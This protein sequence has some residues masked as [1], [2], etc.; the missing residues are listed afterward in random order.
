SAPYILQ[1]KAAPQSEPTA[2]RTPPPIEKSI[3]N[4]KREAS[5]ILVDRLAS[6]IKLFAMEEEGQAILDEME[7]TNISVQSVSTRFWS[8]TYFKL[9]APTQRRFQRMLAGLGFRPGDVG[10]IDADGVQ[11]ILE[12]WIQVAEFIAEDLPQSAG[13]LQGTERGYVALMQWANEQRQQVSQASALVEIRDQEFIAKNLSGDAAEAVRQAAL[14]ALK[15]DGI[16]AL[17]TEDGRIQLTGETEADVLA[18][19]QLARGILANETVKGPGGTKVGIDVDVG[20]GATPADAQAE[21]KASRRPAALPEGV[22]LSVRGQQPIAMEPG[23]NYVPMIGQ[24]GSLPIDANNNLVLG[25]GRKVRIPEQPVRREHILALMQRKFGNRIYQGRV[26]GKMRLGFYRPGHGEIRIKNANDIEVAA[27]EVAHW[28]DDRYPWIS[29]LYRQHRK[30]V[31]SVSYDK[32]KVFEGYAEFMRL[33]M[34]Q[35]SEAMQRVPGFYNAFRQALKDHSELE[36]LVYDL[37][38]LMH[39]WTMQGARARLASKHG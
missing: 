24:T 14:D 18:A 32:K 3:E 5:D 12:D 30:E 28:L 35:E 11:H 38:E 6:A 26:K 17:V 22:T 10:W 39:A 23:S 21:L 33:F 1:F 37:Q 13:D 15:Q 4:P 7:D 2:A 29:K 16:D 8:D 27:H 25:N 34:T 9:N 36:G 31:S 19:T 20:I